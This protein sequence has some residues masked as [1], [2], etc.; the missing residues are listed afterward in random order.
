MPVRIDAFMCVMCESVFTDSRQCVL[1]ERNEHQ[2]D[3][4]QSPIALDTASPPVDLKP[5]ESTGQS[6]LVTPAPAK[7]SR[8]HAVAR[9]SDI[10]AV[11]RAPSPELKVVSNNVENDSTNTA[12]T[13]VTP[14]EQWLMN[15]PTPPASS[16][17]GL[18]DG[19]SV[20]QTALTCSRC[21]RAYENADLLIAHIARAHNAH[22]YSCP[23]CGKHY[24]QESNMKTHVRNVHSKKA[25]SRQKV[26]R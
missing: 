14:V 7:R 11:A 24:S 2:H 21:R 20:A 19:G 25:A 16:E 15:E 5:S 6:A 3:D 26:L 4:G 23:H 8:R 9:R 22:T 10:T 18:T 13:G 12:D 17:N 1:H